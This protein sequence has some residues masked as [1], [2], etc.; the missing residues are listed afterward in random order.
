MVGAVMIN[1][2]AVLLMS[3]DADSAEMYAVGL[4]LDGFQPRVV[5]NASGLTSAI[6]EQPPHA[7]V[8]DLTPGWQTGWDLLRELR[9]ITKT[10]DTPV[11]LLFGG[12]DESIRPR[13]EALGCS[14][15]LPKPC[16]PD[17]LAEALR[18]ALQTQPAATATDVGNSFRDP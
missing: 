3:G 17:A 12:A 15:L 11:V 4:S 1:R 14:A 6:A 13:A 16:L 7:V 8:V 2:A 5:A 10:R 9:C 18:S